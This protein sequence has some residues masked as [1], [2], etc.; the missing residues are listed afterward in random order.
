MGNLPRRCPDYHQCDNHCG[1]GLCSRQCRVCS[2]MQGAD[3]VPC[4][5]CPDVVRRVDD[6]HTYSTVA[7]ERDRITLPEDYLRM[8][9]YAMPDDLIGGW[10]I[11]LTEEPP[12]KGGCG[13]GDFISE[14]AARHVVER[15]NLWLQEQAS[16]G[17][18]G[19]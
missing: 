12:S 17:E 4:Q 19:G 13:V 10:C 8:R 1:S 16:L 6:G 5:A 7:E 2:R 14:E 18:F 11:M 15:H 3:S 9:W